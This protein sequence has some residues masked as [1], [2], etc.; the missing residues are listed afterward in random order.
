MG[1]KNENIQRQAIP[2]K[3]KTKDRA[4]VKLNEQEQRILQ[5]SAKKIRPK[6][7][8]KNKTI[9]SETEKTE[10]E[11]TK[12]KWKVSLGTTES[13]ATDK[14]ISAST[15][16]LKIVNGSGNFEATIGFGS[17]TEQTIPGKPE[18]SN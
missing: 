18:V 13:A 9:P 12:S 17:M 6:A 4:S 3:T 8:K 11:K 14:R 5:E 16:G 2:E 1:N 7:E 15:T 10:T